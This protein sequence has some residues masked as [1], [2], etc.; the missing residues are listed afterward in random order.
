MLRIRF[1]RE[2]PTVNL[3]RNV[4]IKRFDKK[5]SVALDLCLK[6]KK[7]FTF[8]SSTVPYIVYVT[9]VSRYYGLFFH[10]YEKWIDEIVILFGKGPTLGVIISNYA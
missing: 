5:P 3:I 6:I 10:F 7:Y 1:L 8:R 9:T 4:S 2:Q